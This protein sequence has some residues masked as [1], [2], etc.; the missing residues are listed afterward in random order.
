MGLVVQMINANGSRKYGMIIM[1]PADVMA[2]MCRAVRQLTR[3]RQSSVQRPC[4]LALRCA[5]PGA[6]RA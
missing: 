4:P 3:P 1:D 2:R 5:Q 6:C